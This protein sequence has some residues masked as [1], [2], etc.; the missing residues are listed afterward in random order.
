M[1]KTM[2]LPVVLYEF[3]TWSLTLREERTY[4]YDAGEQGAEEN[5][6]T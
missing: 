5:I 2:I 6:G 1:H 3:R 4:I